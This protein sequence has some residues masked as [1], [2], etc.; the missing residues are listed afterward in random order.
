MRSLVVFLLL[1]FCTNL[2]SGQ[3]S[4]LRGGGAATASQAKI[5]SVLQGA[6]GIYGN[7][8]TMPEMKDKFS[9]DAGAEQRFGIDEL[10]VFSLCGIMK[11][12]RS[13]VGINLVNLGDSDYLERKFQFSYGMK[14][15]DVLNIGAS[16]NLMQLAISDYGQSLTPSIDLGLYTKVNKVIRLGMFAQNIGTKKSESLSYPTV[17]AFGV[18]YLVST[19]VSIKVEAEKILDRQI[20]IKSALDYAPQERLHLFLG[21][22]ATRQIMSFG[23][24]YGLK[25][26][27]IFG[28]YSA[29]NVLS[30]S[31]SM[32]LRYEK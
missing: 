23:L 21:V 1:G 7:M 28:A 4:D 27:K 2:L 5:Y 6:N 25:G 9:V 30:G 15:T 13:A 14:L 32:N 12:G 18:D 8:S 11:V 31:P 3:I 20:S 10:Q 19:K 22:D 24:S 17:L 29:G 16:F 26:F